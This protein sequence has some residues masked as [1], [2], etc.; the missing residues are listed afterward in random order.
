MKNLLLIIAGIV[1]LAIGTAA[2]TATVIKL[3]VDDQYLGTINGVVQYDLVNSTITLETVE[4]VY[5]CQFDLIH[6]DQ[7]EEDQQ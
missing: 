5:G 6:E 4:G 3:Y 1:L 7:F 2:Y